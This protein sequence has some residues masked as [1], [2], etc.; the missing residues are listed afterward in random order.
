MD[1]LFIGRNF[2]A[3]D[4]LQ[5]L[6]A[7]LDLLG[8][9]RLVAEAVDEGFQ[10]LNALALVAVGGFE[11][12]AALLFLAQIGVVVAAVELDVLVPDFHRSVYRDVEEITVVGDQ[13]VGEGVAE[14]VR[15]EP[16]A[17]FEIEVVGRLVEQQHVGLL[18]EKLR[19]RDAHLPAAGKFFGAAGPVFFVEA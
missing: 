14:Q 10:L 2:D 17:G 9:G 19:E 1:G 15:F 6:D 12:R 4:F 18:Q 5:F 11:L 8:F 3:L 13:D 7:G 16:V